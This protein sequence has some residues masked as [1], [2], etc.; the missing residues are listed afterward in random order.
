MKAEGTAIENYITDI[1]QKYRHG[2]EHWRPS[3]HFTA[4]TSWI[5]DPNGLIYFSGWYHL[6]YQYNPKSCEWGS[7]HWGHAISKDMLHWK[8]MPIALYPDMPYDK[9]DEG[10]CFS[11]SAVEK[12]GMLYFF[13]TATVHQGENVCQTQ[14]VFTSEDG[15][16][17]KKYEGNPVIT[18]PPAGA[19]SDFRDP[20]V[21]KSGEFWYMVIGGSIGGS[22]AAD[23]D[24]CVFLY[25]SED[26]YH[27]DYRGILLESRGEMGTMFECPD[28]F[29]LDGH[30]VLTCSPVRHPKCNK[31]MYCV[32][33]IDFDT[34]TFHIEKTGN[35]DC[36]FDYYAPQSFEDEHG[37]R[38]LIAWENGWLWMPW[39]Y[40]WGPTSEENWRG[41]LSIPRR[42]S[43][44][45]DLNLILQP[46]DGFWDLIGRGKEYRNLMVNSQRRML[47]PENPYSYIVHLQV[48]ISDITSR[49][50][51]MGLLVNQDKCVRMDIDLVNMLFS[52]DKRNADD[53]GK[54]VMTT[55]I[56]SNGDDLDV[57]IL[58]DHSI[59]EIYINNGQ[60][61]ISSNVYPNEDQT[62]FWIGTPYKE[63]VIERLEIREVK[64]VWE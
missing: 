7:M 13:Y 6:F 59:V 23:G 16:H 56:P 17:F 2:K 36:G 44:D 61:C 60:R 35:M 24:G 8:D 26:L 28:L 45:P 52:L 1:R 5:N 4:P 11:G 15:I 3:Y 48:K 54:G 62:G 30:W 18:H 49:Y 53:Y 55:G 38:V 40:D 39:C 25:R 43:L 42:A 46:I 47:L 22:D 41:V 29:W 21:V 64:S 14:S 9:H 50:L 58:V 34:C 57:L 63:A 19:S 33:D 27:W 31:A 20:K 32:G 10:G 12:D 37:N 51:E